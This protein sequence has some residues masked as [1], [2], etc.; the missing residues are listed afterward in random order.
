MIFDFYKTIRETEI[1]TKEARE[2]PE[3]K[4]LLL[5]SWYLRG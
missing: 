4:Q 5:E 2:T 3:Q 1:W